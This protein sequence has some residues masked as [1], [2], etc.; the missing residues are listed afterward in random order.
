METWRGD[1]LQI[2]CH[3]DGR[4]EM[5]QKETE[6]GSKEF[7]TNKLAKLLGLSKEDIRNDLPI[8]VVS[9]GTPKLMVPLGAKDSL[10]RIEPDF[11]GISRFCEEY[12]CHGFYPFYQAQNSDFDVEARQF[13]PQMGINEDPVTGVAAAALGAYLYAYQKLKKPQIVVRQ[14]YN[15]GRGGEIYVTVGNPMKIG[16]YAVTERVEL[17]S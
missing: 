14:G 16:G 3:V 9:T 10:F 2:L 12:N 1:L 11:L 6:Y 17:L 15:M 7:E 8:Q 13:N 5:F 4:I